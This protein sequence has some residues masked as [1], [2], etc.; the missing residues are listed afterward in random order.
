VKATHEEKLIDALN[1]LAEEE[2]KLDGRRAGVFAHW[3]TARADL[4]RAGGEPGDF[5]VLRD[6]EMESVVRRE[7]LLRAR[8]AEEPRHQEALRQINDLAAEERQRL[9]AA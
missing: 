2:R 9:S 8:V 3:V 6:G 1:V 7:H 5:P 4:I